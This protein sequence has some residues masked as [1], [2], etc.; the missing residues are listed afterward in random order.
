MAIIGNLEPKP[1]TEVTEALQLASDDYRQFNT[2][3]LEPAKDDLE[4][5]GRKNAV[6]QHK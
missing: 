4:A 3:I 2:N 5:K 6:D 1:E